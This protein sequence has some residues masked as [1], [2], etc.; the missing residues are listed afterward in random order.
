MAEVTQLGY[1]GIGVYDLE[2]W[3]GYAESL[4]GLE[5]AGREP[6]GSMLLRMDDHH[7]RFAV[8]EDGRDDV[9]Y[10]GWQAESAA[11]VDAI[12]ARLEAGG[13]TVSF[14]TREDAERR[15]VKAL[16]RFLDPDGH[17]CEVFHGPEM[18]ASPF[19]STKGDGGFVA[20]S[21]GLGHL[22]LAVKDLSRA[23]DFYT[24][25]LGMKV[26]DYVTSG[27]TLGFLHCNARHHSIAFV[28]LE[29]PRK[30][31]NHFMLQLESI[32]DVGRTYDSV[33]EGSAPL[34]VTMGRHSND[35]MVS[36]YMANPSRFGVEYGWGGRE[37]DD[38]SWQVEHYSSGSLWGHKPV[39]RSQPSPQT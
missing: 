32:D 34:L 16:I 7:H 8:Q 20:G 21:Q 4:L 37:V 22:V 24:G 12:A 17:E 39:Q 30:R 14:G 28:Q 19:R 13:V 36:F 1:L 35:Q 10:V 2:E 18:A 11:D 23:M 6:D 26:S 15:H 3:R 25:M 9:A 27:M 31:I 5:V 29:R 33:Q 38:C